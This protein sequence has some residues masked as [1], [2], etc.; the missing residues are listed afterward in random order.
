[1]LKVDNGRLEIAKEKIKE[2]VSIVTVL[3]NEGAN[4][5]GQSGMCKCPLHDEGIPSFSYDN[6]RG[7]FNCFSC[8]TKGSVIQLIQA[9]ENTLHGNRLRNVEETV[10]F[11]LN[12]RPDI[13]KMLGFSTIYIEQ[14]EEEKLKYNRDGTINFGYEKRYAPK[15]VE[16]F[17]YQTMSR[18]L[19][20]DLIKAKQSNDAE[21]LLNTINQIKDFITCCEYG[22]GLQMTMDVLDGA[23]ISDRVTLKIELDDN[24]LEELS[25]IF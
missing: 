7:V 20:R 15:R 5:R 19:K 8:G 3:Q 23:S 10:E 25:N 22:M 11:I 24:I 6:E 4:P 14:I 1:M 21:L 17:S 16:T 18:N 12:T 13:C 9:C 2:V